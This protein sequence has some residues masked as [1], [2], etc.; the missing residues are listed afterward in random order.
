MKAISSENLR[1]LQRRRDFLKRRINERGKKEGGDY[2]YEEMCALTTAIQYL[3]FIKQHND[4]Y[5]QIIT[6]SLNEKY[7]DF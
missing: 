6:I 7:L 5:N 1:T 3:E 4:I 2:D